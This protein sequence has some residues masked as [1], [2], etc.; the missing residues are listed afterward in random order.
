M[1]DGRRYAAFAAGTSLRLNRLTWLNAAGKGI[2]GTAA[3]PAYGHAQF[4]P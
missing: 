1:V 2:A 3:L 4:Q